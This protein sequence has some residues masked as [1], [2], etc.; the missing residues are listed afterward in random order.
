MQQEKQSLRDTVKH[1]DNFGTQPQCCYLPTVFV[2]LHVFY[3]PKLQQFAN[4]AYIGQ[5]T[6]T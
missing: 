4:T 1:H 5:Y 6:I 2:G 3:E